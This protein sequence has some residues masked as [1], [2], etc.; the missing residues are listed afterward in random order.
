MQ[1]NISGKNLD[2]GESLRS[3]LE[4][5][6][7]DLIGKYLDRVTGTTVVLTREAHLYRADIVVSPGTHTHLVIKARG[8]ATDAHPACEQ[9]LEKI[10]KQLRRYK[11]RLTS[12][13]KPKATGRA[14]EAKKYVLRAE[15][16][17]EL[18]PESKESGLII[19]EKTTGVQTLSVGE[20]VMKMDLED[21]PAVMFFN[22]AHGGLN[23]VY[24]RADG[25]ISWVD[26][27][28]SHA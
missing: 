20:A 27:Q 3:T 14:V 8:E 9:A 25:N 26:P 13:H 5:R 22:P 17:H 12:H 16:G 24:R 1:I 28:P 19:A 10:E 15:E 7:N 2:V 18:P 11:Q 6:L 21:L 4:Q 23:V